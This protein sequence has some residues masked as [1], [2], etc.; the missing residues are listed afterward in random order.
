[1][2]FIITYTNALQSVSIIIKSVF[3]IMDEII[4]IQ[5]FLLAYMFSFMFRIKVRVNPKMILFFKSYSRIVYL[6]ML[7]PLSFLVLAM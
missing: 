4:K 1:M 7:Q 2:T 3:W 6:H 5:L